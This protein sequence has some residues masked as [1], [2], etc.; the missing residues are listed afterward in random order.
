MVIVLG[1]QVGGHTR[2]LLLNQSTICKPL[3]FRELDFYQNL[4]REIDTFVPKYKGK[5]RYDHLSS[6][7]TAR[8][9]LLH[10]NTRRR[11]HRNASPTIHDVFAL[12]GSRTYLLRSILVGI[13]E[14]KC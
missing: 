12:V 9:K 1:P 2:L 8:I 4:P 6:S 10:S 7:F 3:N 14:E 11:Q 5:T 13:S